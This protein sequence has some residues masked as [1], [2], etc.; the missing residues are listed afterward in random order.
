MKDGNGQKKEGRLKI[1][2]KGKGRGLMVS[3]VIN[4]HDCFL[5]ITPAETAHLS[6]CNAREI[7]KYGSDQESYWNNEKFMEWV[8]IA[9]DD[10]ELKYPHDKF[11][12]V[13]LFDQSS[14]HCAYD[15]DALGVLRMNVKPGGK[16]QVM[17]TTVSP[18]TGKPQSLVDHAGIPKGMKQV[19]KERGVNTDGMKAEDIRK[20]LGSHRDFKYEKPEWSIIFIKEVIGYFSFPSTC[21]TVS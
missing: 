14:G 8:K 6:R 11:S 15:E 7:L 19:L 13:G 3:D 10:A 1:K 12:I 20:V 18:L 16:Q 4:K 21:T 5:A 2:P 17:R 9:A